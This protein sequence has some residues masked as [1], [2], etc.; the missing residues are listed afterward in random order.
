MFEIAL[1][2]AEVMAPAVTTV[3][4][5][6]AADVVVEV[7]AVAVDSEK[8]VAQVGSVLLEMVLVVGQVGEFDI[9][10]QKAN[11]GSGEAGAQVDSA[12]G[13]EAC[14]KEVAEGLESHLVQVPEP[15]QEALQAAAEGQF[16]EAEQ[17]PTAGCLHQMHC[18]FF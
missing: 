18:Q 10:D 4:A 5:A 7:V 15:E 13:W 3:V 17:E 8:I 14:N 6:G 1:R 16:D 12:E 9:V 2:V 11:T